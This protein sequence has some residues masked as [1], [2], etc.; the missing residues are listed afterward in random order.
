MM[1]FAR[2]FKQIPCRHRP[3]ESGNF[4]PPAFG[5]WIFARDAVTA[6]GMKPHQLQD[7]I[8]A[9]LVRQNGGERRRW[10]S[11]LGPMRI[12]DLATHPHCNWSYSPAGS[13]RENAAIERLLDD[14]RGAHP[15]VT[16]G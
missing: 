16:A 9:T 15:I 5:R 13:V 14:L 6:S 12:H 8:V 1:E 3:T 10:R 11:A 2:T 7:L 4:A